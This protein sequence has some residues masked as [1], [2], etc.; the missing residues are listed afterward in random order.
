[1]KKIF[2]LM[3]AAAIL[4]VGC[5]E[6][7]PN[8]EL[9]VAPAGISATA[10]ADNYTITV[11]GNVS[12][13]ATA[14][15]EWLS[16]TPA[17]GT[18]DGTITVRVSANAAPAERTATVTVAGDGL[19]ETV[20]VTQTGAA[21]ILE[22]DNT[23]IAAGSAAGSY[24]IAITSN[25]AWTAAKSAEW[26]TL[27]PASGN[28]NGTLTVAVS[29]NTTT[30][31]RTATVTLTAGNLSKTVTV[32]QAGV[33]AATPPHAASTN[34]WVIGEQTW[35]DHIN[36]PAC[37]KTDFNSGSAETPLADCRNNPGYNYLYSWDYVNQNAEALCPAPWRVPTSDDYCTLDM[38]LNNYGSCENNRPGVLG[39]TYNAEWG[40]IYGGHCT[41]DGTLGYHGA[42]AYYWSS[43][44]YGLTGGYALVY[45]SSLVYP[46]IA[47][48][49][50]TGL[51]VRCVR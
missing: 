29:T 12:W 36:L 48:N 14:N 43:S 38:A 39:D 35:S 34:T 49:R 9:S 1:M 50:Y 47:T 20:T 17:S 26:L 45:A 28:G 6:D 8:Y 30:D 16:I 18:N 5:K 10:S 11:T 32:S 2:A 23:A 41:N 13:S 46:Q 7:E 4:F 31:T 24:A 33:A 40:G 27:N 15:A 3:L 22:V 21:A 51:N 19:S 44:E 25:T 37:D 42:G